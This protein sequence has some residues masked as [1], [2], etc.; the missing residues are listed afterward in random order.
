MATVRRVVAWAGWAAEW[1]SKP[2]NTLKRYQKPRVCG[3]SFLQSIREALADLQTQNRC[4]SA[5]MSTLS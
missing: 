3:A 5:W 4:G 1:I 2:P